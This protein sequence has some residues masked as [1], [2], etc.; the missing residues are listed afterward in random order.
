MITAIMSFVLLGLLASF[1]VHTDA[2]VPSSFV[3][4][5]SRG[6]VVAAGQDVDERATLPKKTPLAPASN[7]HE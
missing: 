3:A 6:L 2:F 1:L 7:R 4:A 5:R